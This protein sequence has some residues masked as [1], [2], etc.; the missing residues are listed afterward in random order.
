MKRFLILTSVV[1]LLVWASPVGA[2]TIVAQTIVAQTTPTPGRVR[3]QDAWQQVYKDVPDLALENQYV[4]R[5]TGK[6]D[7][8]NTLVTRLIRYHYFIKGRP[9][10]F[11]LDWKYTLADYLGINDPMQAESYPGSDNLRKNPFESDR[12]I[13]KKLNRKQRDALVQALVNVFTRQQ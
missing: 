12:A 10:S 11:R 9:V 1:A 3:I 5:E 6:A 4:N 7:P 13:I 8:S 2:Q